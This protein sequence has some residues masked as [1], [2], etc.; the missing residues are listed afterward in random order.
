MTVEEKEGQ[1]LPPN[2]EVFK[3]LFENA[4]EGVIVSNKQGEILMA[5]PAASEMFGYEVDEL[6]GLTIEDL[7]PPRYLDHHEEYRKEYF[8]K[9]VSRPMGQGRNLWGLRKDNT[10]FPVEISLSYFQVKKNI[11]AISYIIDITER[12]EQEVALEKEKKKA[13]SYLDLAGSM[14]LALNEKGKV[15]MINESGKEILGYSEEEIVGQDWFDNFI[16]ARIRGEVKEVFDRLIQGQ[17]QKFKYYE[18]PVITRKNKERLIAFNNNVIHDDAGRIVGVLCSGDDITEQ[19]KAEQQLKKVNSELKQYARELERSNKELKQ[20]AYVASHDLK[21]PLRMVTSYTQLLARRYEDQLDQTALEFIN[22]AVDGAQRMNRLIND[23]LQYS[24]V[25]RQQ[26]HF[27]FVSLQDIIDMAQANLASKIEDTGA[28]LE[29]P[30]S[31]P[32]LPGNKTLLVQLFQNLISNAIKFRKNNCAPH[33]TIT[34][35][36]LSAHWR[37]GVEDNGIGIPEKHQERIFMIFQR[38]HA[39]D[40]Y[41]GS[42]IGLALC[43]KIVDYHNGS[44]WLESEEGKGTTF[45]VELPKSGKK[46]EESNKE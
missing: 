26:Q 39:R 3:A 20:F 42:G 12:R 17:I 1:H 25:G 41:T 19:K 11:F 32:R 43:H 30:S 8:R 36:E 38:L 44:I 33:I 14:F 37:I 10:Q 15:E 13:Q 46:K 16:P 29:I 31:L 24:R 28:E 5:N 7:V 21:E 34:I 40:E 45:Y 18:N 4:T 23:L 6:I 9:P 27:T 35:K 22:Y 2:Y